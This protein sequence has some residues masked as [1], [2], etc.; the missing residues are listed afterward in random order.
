[1]QNKR[2][3]Y[4][5]KSC[6]NASGDDIVSF[7]RLDSV[8]NE[9]LSFWRVNLAVS[10][11]VLYK[12]DE[13]GVLQKI[14]LFDGFAMIREEIDDSENNGST[15]E[16]SANGSTVSDSAISVLNYIKNRIKQRRQANKNRRVTQN[17]QSKQWAHEIF[18]LLD[19]A[20]STGKTITYKEVMD[21]T[22]KSIETTD[23]ELTTKEFEQ[24]KNDEM[25][26]GLMQRDGITEEVE[27]AED[28]MEKAGLKKS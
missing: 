2:L 22:K 20:K 12:E 23:E 11:A 14:K 8:T 18:G 10:R 27:S 15:F 4:A 3:N 6:L 24:K 25:L 1:M 17:R 13:K 16:V 26:A 21:K 9:E 28:I 7:V 19:S 5:L